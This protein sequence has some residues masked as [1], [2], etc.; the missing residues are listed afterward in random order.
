MAWRTIERVA[1]GAVVVAVQRDAEWDDY[2]AR[3]IHP[4][5]LRNPDADYHTEDK[6]DAIE[7]ARRIAETASARM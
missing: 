6:A 5:R 7:T 2:R 1:V 3:I 4:A